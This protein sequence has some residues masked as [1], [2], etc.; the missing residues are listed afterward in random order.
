[1]C[2]SAGVSSLQ[3][4]APA[5]LPAVTRLRLDTEKCS[6][7]GVAVCRSPPAEDCPTQRSSPCRDNTQG[8]GAA[9]TPGLKQEVDMGH[10]YAM[11]WVGPPGAQEKTGMETT[12]ILATKEE[13]G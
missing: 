12:S 1:M 8:Q 5:L 6:S 4:L 2:C 3:L 11:E 10:L 13:E 9:G 7:G